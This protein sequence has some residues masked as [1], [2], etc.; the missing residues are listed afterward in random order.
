MALWSFRRCP[1]QS[2]G[3][4]DRNPAGFEVFL[5]ASAYSPFPKSGRQP[6]DSTL[7]LS[8]SLCDTWFDMCPVSSLFCLCKSIGNP[9][10]WNCGSTAPLRLLDVLH[11]VLLESAASRCVPLYTAATHTKPLARQFSWLVGSWGLNSPVV[12]LSW[13]QDWSRHS[14]CT[15]VRCL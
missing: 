11:D 1:P 9:L 5:S 14:P 3:I 2:F 12:T 13:K 10:L 6:A 15:A 7:P 8:R 4:L